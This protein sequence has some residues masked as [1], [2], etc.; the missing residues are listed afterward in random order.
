MMDFLMTSGIAAMCIG[1]ISAAALGAVLWVL[2]MNMLRERDIVSARVSFDAA[3]RMLES[4]NHVERSLAYA[5]FSEVLDFMQRFSITEED[6]GSHEKEVIRL[7]DA[8]LAEKHEAIAGQVHDA[9]DMAEV[10][11]DDPADTGRV[12]LVLVPPQ[13]DLEEGFKDA[14]YLVDS[15]D[16]IKSD[17]EVRA[18]IDR[19]MA[20]AA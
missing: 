5:R 3:R 19:I 14:D 18:A 12:A 15:L 1:G 11:E 2:H 8:C 10:I 6:I 16:E 9:T 17:T 4:D 13:P 7:R 20:A